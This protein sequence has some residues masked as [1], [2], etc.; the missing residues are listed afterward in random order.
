MRPNTRR[1]PL[2]EI[3]FLAVLVGTAAAISYASGRSMVLTEV[4]SLALKPVTA[5]T[6]AWGQTVDKVQSVRNLEAE[7]AGLKTRIQELE[8]QLRDR[9]EAAREN[10]RLAT[11]LKLRVPEAAKPITVARVVGRSPD[12]WHQRLILDKGSDAGIQKHCVV[13]NQQGLIGK[14]VAVGPSTALVSLLTDPTMAVSVLNTRTRSAGVVQGQGDPYPVLRYMEQP[15]KWKVGDRLITSGLA[16]TFPKGLPVGK[17]VK[18]Q[19]AETG[20]SSDLR[21]QSQVAMDTIEEV[22]LMPPGLVEMPTPPPKPKPS[23]KPSGSP[24]PKPTPTPRG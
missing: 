9:E 7:N 22:I 8:Q 17:I 24:A 21:V 1:L 14:V 5:V 19:N 4:V 2:K 20:V 10:Q 16:G 23:P 12:N 13:A 18:L 15:E 3:A 11:L 6:G